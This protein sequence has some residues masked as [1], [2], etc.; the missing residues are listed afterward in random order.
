M[1]LGD[2]LWSLRKL[3]HSI[4]TVFPN[5]LIGCLRTSCGATYLE[6]CLSSNEGEIIRFRVLSTF[7]D[8]K[9]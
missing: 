8:L 3:T 1:W 9:G 4:E 7:L 6:S 5:D 2:N